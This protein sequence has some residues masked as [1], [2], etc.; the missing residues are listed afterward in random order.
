MRPRHLHHHGR[1]PELMADGG[2]RAWAPP[3][4][5]ACCSACE[6]RCLA[7]LLRLA[8]TV[9]AYGYLSRHTLSKLNQTIGK[10]MI[11]ARSNVTVM[12]RQVLTGM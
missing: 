12:Q 8:L 3:A 11:L 9:H 2:R 5:S 1:S 6:P 4:R 10:L 7:E